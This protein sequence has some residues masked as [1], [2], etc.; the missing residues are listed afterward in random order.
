[1]KTH[2][3]RFL[4][5]PLIIMCL[6]ALLAAAAP[7]QAGNA[8]H[9]DFV[10]FVDTPGY[11]P[12]PQNGVHWE[13]VFIIA[14]DASG[15][16]DDCFG[17]TV[18][19]SDPNSIV[20]PNHTFGQFHTTPWCPLLGAIDWNFSIMPL[21]PGPHHLT[22]TDINNPSIGRSILTFNVDPG[23]VSQIALAPM[24]ASAILGDGA[25]FNIIARDRLGFQATNYFGSVNVTNTDSAAVTP[26]TAAFTGGNSTF[27]V[28]FGTLG[29]QWIAVTDP[30]NPTLT[31]TARI[32]VVPA[33]HF[34]IQLPVVWNILA[35][36]PTQV[37][38]C[39]INA[40][41]S[42]NTGYRG[43]ITWTSS[44]TKADLPIDYTFTPTDQ[45]CTSPNITFMT[46]GDQTL[47]ATD[48]VNSNITGTAAH[49]ILGGDVTKLAFSGVPSAMIAGPLGVTVNVFD[50]WDNPAT[51]AFVHFACDDPNASVPANFNF[52]IP[53]HG[54][55]N[56]QFTLPTARITTCTATSGYGQT[57]I[58]ESFSVNV[59]AGG[60]GGGARFHISKLTSPSPA[61]MRDSVRVTVAD[62]YGN[63]VKSYRSRVH[64]TSTDPR[65]S[66][67][68]DYTFTAADSGSHVF[69]GVILRTAG[70]QSVT[71][72]DVQTSSVKGRKTNT[73]AM[74]RR[75]DLLI[76]VKKTTRSQ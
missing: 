47:T 68:A 22:I 73:A 10:Y 50:A 69:D 14:L 37:L 48:T 65:A 44:D 49:T 39:A 74:V 24:S 26:G 23:P 75:G 63:R 72:A 70:R 35:G 1:M 71:V 32:S 21:R 6:L 27:T 30:N 51:A 58:S 41:G 55:H 28:K 13:G 19:Y 18:T 15:Q 8:T 66:L 61:G 67:P 9:F 54:T 25:A 29:T 45:G 16:Q 52:R 31:A 33:P 57:N 43:T 17:D 11:T 56:F 42:T 34:E 62:G 53:D 5:V 4:T 46:A 36:I 59:L 2:S 38:Y 12:E 20:T 7:A 64:F 60:G 3:V 40:N 76:D